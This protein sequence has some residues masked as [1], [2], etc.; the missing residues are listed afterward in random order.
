MFDD[1]GLALPGSSW[2]T[3]K[4][5]IRAFSAAHNEENP[6]VEEIAQ[7][8]GVQRPV[9]SMNNNFLRSVGFVRVDQW[10]LTDLGLRYALALEMGNDSMAAENLAELVRAQPILSQA[11]SVIRA[12]GELK[13]DTLKAEVMVRLGVHQSDRRAQFVKPVLDMLQESGLVRMMDDTVT[14]GDSGR[15]GGPR[16]EELPQ[17][18]KPPAPLASSPAMS[19]GLPILLGPNRLAYLQLPSDWEKKD[20]PKLLKMLQLALGDDVE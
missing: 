7:L 8:A 17:S 16:L 10:K 19:E 9:V 11:V 12:R 15:S 20:L 4:R 18:P 2:D 14:I 13:I 5:I 3:V 6:K 1:K